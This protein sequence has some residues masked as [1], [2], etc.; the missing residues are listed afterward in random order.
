MNNNRIHII[1]ELIIKIRLKTITFEERERFL[2][3]LR[4]SEENR[5]I[6]TEIITGK[7]MK[8]YFIDYKN[9][10]SA[11]DAAKVSQEIYTILEARRIAK[12]KHNF[13]LTIIKISSVAA[14]LIFI[15]FLVIKPFF[16]NREDE[17]RIHPNPIAEYVVPTIITTLQPKDATQKSNV[18]MEVALSAENNRTG[19]IAEYISDQNFETETADVKVL[20]EIVI[21]KGQTYTVVLTDGSEVKLNAQSKLSFYSDFSTQHREVVLEGEAFFKVTHSK[22][23]FIVKNK[24]AQI[25]V[26]GTS[27]NVNTR[28]QN[29]IKT[30][31]L[32]GSVSMK[33]KNNKEYFL[34]PG[35]LG[36]MNTLTNQVEIKAVECDQY[37]G[38]L[39]GYIQF[40]DA[41][42]NDLVT[43]MENWYDIQIRYN[44]K[45]FST[46]KVNISVDR[47]LSK[48]DAIQFVEKILDVKFIN[49]G[50]YY[51]LESL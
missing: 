23:P 28:D 19:H 38:W 40:I 39:N 9:N 32:E 42:M 25:K 36:N 8:K 27:F 51:E 35:E 43:E 44:K 46:Q 48:D 11:L 22:I 16:N 47:N 30:I 1:A 6:Y 17:K 13:K 18:K 49:E 21:P 24:N 37:L 34:H 12:R 4:E 3:W 31:L 2:L 50:K 41:P 26:Y 45:E 5:N 20:R 7:S 14:A 15:S 33:S 29:I 10:Q